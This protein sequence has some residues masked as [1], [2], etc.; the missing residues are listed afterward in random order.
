[1]IL[2]NSAAQR[3]YLPSPSEV[4]DNLQIHGWTA[5]TG[6]RGHKEQ[7]QRRGEALPGPCRPPRG[8]TQ[9]RARIGGLEPPPGSPR[10]GRALPAALVTAAAGAD[11]ATAAWLLAGLMPTAHKAYSGSYVVV[12]RRLQLR[13][14]SIDVA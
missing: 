4:V 3:A 5:P 10:A 13:T 1:M 9:P 6:R 11:S 12:V 8:S 7:T 14:P 2:V